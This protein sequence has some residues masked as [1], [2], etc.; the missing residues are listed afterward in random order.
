VSRCA[1]ALGRAQ[2]RHVH[3]YDTATFRRDANLNYLPRSAILTCAA[4]THPPPR[5][6]RALIH[7]G[8]VQTIRTSG[9]T[10]H[11]AGDRHGPRVDPSPP[12]RLADPALGFAQEGTTEFPAQRGSHE[13]S[14]S[15]IGVY[16]GR[17]RRS[18]A[19][20]DHGHRSAVRAYS[21][22][23][24]ARCALAVD[25]APATPGADQRVNS[26]GKERAELCGCKRCSRSRPWPAPRRPPEEPT[27]PDAWRHARTDSRRIITTCLTP[28][29][30]LILNG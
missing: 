15:F 23:T 28:A 29:A 9:S 25:L 5:P 12:A 30:C 10:R 13:N 21:T 6:R 27:S 7:A 18:R 14:R 22:A 17:R 19:H 11:G 1:G 16:P 8:R 20:R 3:F 2:R 26:H 4:A 24:S